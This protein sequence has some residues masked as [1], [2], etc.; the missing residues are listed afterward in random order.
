MARVHGGEMVAR[1][2]QA[3]GVRELF[4]LHGGHIDPILE[5]CDR[6]GFRIVDTR[7]E[8]AAAHMA[9][10][11]ARTT[12]RLGVC[13]VTAG[14]GVTD[15]VTGVANAF[16]DCVP[17][18]VLGGRSPLRDED[19]LPLQGFPQLE[20]MR[21]ITKWARCVYHPERIPEYVAMAIRHATTGRPG[22]VYLELPIDVLFAGRDEEQVAW[23]EALRP[24]HPPAARPEAVEAVLELLAR[25]ERPVI[26]AGGGV[27]FSGAADL[28]REFA[29]VTSVPVFMNAK[30]RGA[31]PE[32]TPLGY[33]GFALFSSGLVQ[34]EAGPADVVLVLG[35]RLG[36][37]TGGRRQ[38]IIPASA[39][40]VQV[41]IEGEEIG[42]NRDVQLGVEAD[43]R[44]FLRQ[45][46]EAARGRRWPER[47]RW[48]EVLEQA[49]RE[50]QGAF[51]SALERDD[52]PIH[53]FRLAHELAQRLGPD[54]VVV[55]DGGEAASWI[56]DAVAMRRPGRFLS[57]GYLGCLGVGLPFAAA[58]KLAH[59]EGRVLLVI[60]DGSVGLNFAEFDTAV[61]HGLPF[62]CV[63]FNDKAWGMSRHGQQIMFQGRTIAT[64]LGLVHYEK[65]AAGFGVH[66]EL[67]TR[68][69]EIGPALERAWATGQ[70]A[71][72]NALIDPEVI[73]PVTLAMMGLPAAP[74]PQAA[75]DQGKTVLP[76]YGQREL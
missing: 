33:G 56:G 5:A 1:V 10:A 52:V 36:L 32:D 47:T 75:K 43:C 13:A 71:C 44:E 46:L 30:A 62:A 51:A 12:G 31:V 21:P 38:S 60:G 27:W 16:M 66:P 76:Y 22:P 15:A 6:L 18:L 67:V 72:I 11:W 19:T 55:A 9:D 68:P 7:H 42:R 34:R 40:V 24:E 69:Q 17:M 35:A 39:T 48:L 58:C 74:T 29:Q 70:V 50:R 45:A 3:A 64:D 57:H 63:I 65:A 28:L 25:A 23:P 73:A 49:Q 8:Q 41:D 2:L 4:T 14:P 54:D 37:F 61:R 59:P 20:M 53:P 26:L